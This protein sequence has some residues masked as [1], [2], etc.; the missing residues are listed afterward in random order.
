METKCTSHHKDGMHFSVCTVE[1][2]VRLSSWQMFLPVAAIQGLGRKEQRQR[3]HPQ[4]GRSGSQPRGDSCKTGCRQTLIQFTGLQHTERSSE[5]SQALGVSPGPNSSGAGVR[6]FLRRKSSVSWFTS[7][8]SL[9][10]GDF[11]LSEMQRFLHNG[12]H[13]AC[14]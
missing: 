12:S 7:K 8:R 9:E 13:L 1:I 6:R 10:I 11:L 5:Q 4:P 14:T 3:R 2:C